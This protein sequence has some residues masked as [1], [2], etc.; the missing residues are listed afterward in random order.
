MPETRAGK[1]ELEL[2]LAEEVNHDLTLNNISQDE[3]GIGQGEKDKKEEEVGEDAKKRY[4]WL[5]GSSSGSKNS[6][7]LDHK[8]FLPQNVIIKKNATT[9]A[10]KS[11]EDRIVNGYEAGEKISWTDRAR[12]Q[13]I[14]L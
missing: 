13:N 7:K 12:G 9:K 14:F 4:S 3:D 1:L 6:T 10:N 5:E 11:D 8:S 2:K